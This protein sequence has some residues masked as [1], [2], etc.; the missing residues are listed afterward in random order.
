M[1]TNYV[2]IDYENVQPKTLDSLKGDHHFKVLLFVG[3]SQTKVSFEV[4][5]SMQA[6]GENARYIKIAGNGPNALDF[7]I[8]YYIGQLSMQDANAFFHIISKDAGFDPLIKHLKEHK[9]FACRSKNIDEIPMLRANH[10]ARTGKAEELMGLVLANL[11]QRV[12]AKPRSIKTLTNTIQALFSKRLTA[13]EVE[14]LLETMKAT[15]HITVSGTKVS[16][17]QSSE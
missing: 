5:E 3:S 16:Y 14:N 13:E 9:V 1:K 15:G 8:A 12:K 2:L 6:L 7:H 17:A 4:A 11:R 10:V